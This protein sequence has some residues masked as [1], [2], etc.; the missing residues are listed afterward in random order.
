V[1]SW[2]SREDDHF[3]F[4]AE[5]IRSLRPKPANH[6]TPVLPDNPVFQ[7]KAFPQLLSLRQSAGAVPSVR[8]VAAGTETHYK[9]GQDLIALRSP[10]CFSCKSPNTFAQEK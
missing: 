9:P 8:E 10:T 7:D 4:Q 1:F 5:P 3:N 6:P 2:L